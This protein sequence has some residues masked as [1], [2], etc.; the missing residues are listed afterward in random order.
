MSTSHSSAFSFWS[1]YLMGDARSWFKYF[2][3]RWKHHW[4][5]ELPA[6]FFISALLTRQWSLQIC[7]SMYLSRLLQSSLAIRITSSMTHFWSD[8]RVHVRLDSLISWLS[9]S[10]T[11]LWYMAAVAMNV[12]TLLDS[13]STPSHASFHPF[14]LCIMR[15][16][17]ALL[18]R[19]ALTSVPFL[20]RRDRFA[21]LHHP[22][23]TMVRNL[24]KPLLVTQFVGDSLASLPQ[25]LG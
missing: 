12:R 2:T 23:I 21:S 19:I 8:A 7:S 22:R 9:Y 1:Y 13:S 10:T 5:M 16:I 14:C 20:L 24:S 17:L 3:G 11:L 4:V 6:T 25:L 15:F 18:L